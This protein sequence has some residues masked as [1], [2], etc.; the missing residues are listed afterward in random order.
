MQLLDSFGTNKNLKQNSSDDSNLM[1]INKY[2]YAMQTEINPSDSYK[3]TNTK[4]LTSL[5]RFHKGKF[6]TKMEREDVIRYLN[7]LRKPDDALHGW[8]G[9]DNLYRIL[10]IR[11]FKWLYNPKLEPQQRPRPEVVQNI[12]KLKRKEVSIYKPTDL[13][14][15]E[16]DLLFLKWC[17]K[18]YQ[19][20]H[21]RCFH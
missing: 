21:M 19:L 2:L 10:L 5:S 15:L 17:P 13:W 8:I 9:T 3:F 6:F 1:I 20:G 4:L 16:D 14:T 7:S 11:F 12:P 18:T